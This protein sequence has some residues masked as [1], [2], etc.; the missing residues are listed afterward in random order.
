M[1]TNKEIVINIIEDLENKNLITWLRKCKLTKVTKEKLIECW[2]QNEISD[3]KFYEYGTAGSLS[4]AYSKI[5]KNMHKNS[6]Q[7]WKAYIL[8]LYE[9]KY[10]AT[11]NN[12]LLFNMFNISTREINNRDNS[13]KNCLNLRNRI[14]YSKHLDE[15]HNRSKIYRENNRDKEVARQ[16]IYRENN[17]EKERDR[18]KKYYSSHKKEAFARSALRRA[19]KIQRTPS[20]ADAE[21]MK[22][23][24]INCPE[25]YHVDHKNPLQGKLVSGLH[26][27]NNLQYLTAEENLSKGNKYEVN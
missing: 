14:R 19:R 26:V 16:K 1:K 8:S 25:G 27:E 10:C 22:E 21:K 20:W 13:C 15:E 23:I 6:K 4:K 24:Y 5:F 18:S 11:C 17:K 9:Y 2:S 7:S 3:W 12:L